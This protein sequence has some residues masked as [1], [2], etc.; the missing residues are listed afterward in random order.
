SRQFKESHLFCLDAK[1]MRVIWRVPVDLPAWGSPV[2]DGRQV[3]FGL[4]NGRLNRSDDNPAGA[5]VCLDAQFGREL[6]RHPV[7]DSVLALP[8]VDATR[9]FFTCRDGTVTALERAKGQLI[10]SRP[11]GSPIVT[12]PALFDGRIYVT[13]SAGALCALNSETGEILATFD[14]KSRFHREAIVYA[15]QSVVREAAS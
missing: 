9:V 6:W 8:T 11:L 3:F 4:G 15:S 1:S 10:W 13:T 2:V 5:L 12:R 7:P 14:L